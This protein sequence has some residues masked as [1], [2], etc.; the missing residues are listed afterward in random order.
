LIEFKLNA[1]FYYPL[2]L[3][4]GFHLNMLIYVN[5][6]ADRHFRS[7]LNL[8]CLVD[9]RYCKNKLICLTLS[10]RMRWAGHVAWMGEGRNVYS[11]LMGKPKGKRPL[12]RPRCRGED[13]IKMDLREIGWGVW[14]GFTWLGIGIV[15]GLL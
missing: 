2:L 3:T 13:G 5:L 10:W 6:F 14:S 9:A 7:Q 11:V 4:D 1:W 12:G 15:G 8:S